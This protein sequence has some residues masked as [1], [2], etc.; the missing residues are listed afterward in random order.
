[1]AVTLEFH[2]A[3]G[4]VYLDGGLTEDGKLIRKSQTYRNIKENVQP[5]DLHK[6]LKQIAQL[7]ELRFIG[8]ELVET[9]SVID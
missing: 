7:S 8:A 5:D 6:A 3:V 4:R 9:S 1:M 2:Q